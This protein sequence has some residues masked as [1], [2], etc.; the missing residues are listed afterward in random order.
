MNFLKLLSVLA[1]CLAFTLKGADFPVIAALDFTQPSI[2]KIVRLYCHSGFKG[3]LSQ[4]IFDDIPALKLTVT[5]A[6]TPPKNNA[7]LQLRIPVQVVI[8]SGHE[9]RL[10]FRCRAEQPFVFTF[11]NQES[12][13]P[14]KS[15]SEKNA[16]SFRALTT[17]QQVEFCFTATRDAT[18]ILW[19][20]N[21]E[22]AQLTAGNS[23]YLANLKFEQLD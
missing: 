1:F 20:P 18:G 23:F 22:L 14:W 8:K 15:V 7:Q 13:S 3:S 6:Q 2:T 16:G 4:G 10:S 12:I 21:F 19:V 17:W 9:Y 5:E 11:R